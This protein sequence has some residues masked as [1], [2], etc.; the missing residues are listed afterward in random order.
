[1]TLKCCFNNSLDVGPA[2]ED[3][4][5]HKQITVSLRLHQMQVFNGLSPA[6]FIS[7]LFNQKFN[8]TEN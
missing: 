3:M 1:M 5:N 7:G 2:F 8:F 4:D 6:S